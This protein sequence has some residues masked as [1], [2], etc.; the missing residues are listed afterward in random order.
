MN[1]K[2]IKKLLNK[3]V[4]KDA[5]FHCDDL[6]DNFIVE[7]TTYGYEMTMRKIENVKVT[8]VRFCL[9]DHAKVIF[10]FKTADGY[11]DESQEYYL[12]D[13]IA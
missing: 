4:S 7:H 12:E 11:S 2:E 9:R 1:R 3:Y 5:S 13:F 6:I 8:L 10:V